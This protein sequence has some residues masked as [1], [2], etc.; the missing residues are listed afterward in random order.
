MT[1]P[2]LHILFERLQQRVA[3]FS[4]HS[5]GV[6]ALLHDIAH[7]MDAVR[8][9]HW[10]EAAKRPGHPTPALEVLWPPVLA[11]QRH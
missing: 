6:S 8:L 2:T 1:T 9:R 11:R 4:T 10:D 5:L 7:A 3:L